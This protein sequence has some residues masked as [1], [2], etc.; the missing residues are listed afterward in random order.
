MHEHAAD[1][2]V[3]VVGGG[4][5]ATTAALFSARHGHATVVLAGQPGGALLS[6]TRIDDFPGFPE[7]VAGYD[8][9]PL[10]QEQAMAAGAS[11][12]MAE[13][14]TL[15]PV[16]G[17]WQAGADGAAVTARAVIVA[18]GSRPRT[19]DVPGEERLA[20]RGISHCASCDGPLHR[21]GVVGVVGGG[22]SALQE[23]LELAGFAAEVV[24]IHRGATFRAQQVYQDGIAAAPQIS[25][26][27]RT[28]VEEVLGDDRVTG[29]R[30]RELADGATSELA[31]G[32]LFVY[33]GAVPHTSFLEGVVPLGPEGHV[34]T[35]PWMRTEQPGLFAAGAVRADSA[36][37]A[38]TAAGDGATAAVAAH[39]Y[40]VGEA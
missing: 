32:A 36:A 17:G 10:A 16:D 19:L 33:A 27:Y 37:Q 7:G 31:L 4:L 15:E 6:V 26:R 9:C 25:V 5:A 8:L 40:L 23:S 29:V 18:S 28:V 30:V 21:D 22:D 34:A 35:D 13:L 39:R 1:C 14:E 38:I 11:F 12:R 24:L 2:E 20:G 3:L